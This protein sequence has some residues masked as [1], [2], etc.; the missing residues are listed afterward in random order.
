MI[1]FGI[2]LALL[3]LGLRYWLGRRA[4]NRRNAAGVELFNSYE[5]AAG[6]RL[7]EGLGHKLG[8]LLLFVGGLLAV[9]GYLGRH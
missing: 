1:V 7:L 2:V 5:S 3:G 4:F 9:F 6:N 8:G